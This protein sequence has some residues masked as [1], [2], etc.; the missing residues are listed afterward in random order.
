MEVDQGGPN[1]GEKSVATAPRGAFKAGVDEKGRLKLPARFVEYFKSMGTE[2]FL[3]SIDQ[4]SARIYPI[5][6][7]EENLRLMEARRDL[8][9]QFERLARVADHYGQDVEIDAQGRLLI[10]PELRRKLGFEG[11]PVWLRTF[12]GVV[13][14]FSQADYE[15]RLSESEGLAEQDLSAAAGVGFK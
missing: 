6:L 11:Q 2:V 15:R 14:V 8:S 5:P 9:A 3:T 7:W 13:H 10:H 1:A 4:V 12:Q